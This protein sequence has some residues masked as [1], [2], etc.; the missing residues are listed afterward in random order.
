[1]ALAFPEVGP[2]VNLPFYPLARFDCTPVQS[3]PSSPQTVG[4]DQRALLLRAS[5]SLLRESVGRDSV[6]QHDMLLLL[7]LQLESVSVERRGATGAVQ[8]VRATD[9]AVFFVLTSNWRTVIYDHAAY[10]G[11]RPV[12]GAH[13]W[14][15][16]ASGAQ[17][18]LEAI[19]YDGMQ[20]LLANE[21]AERR[22]GMTAEEVRDAAV[23]GADFNDALALMLPRRSV[24]SVL[25]V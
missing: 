20:Q 17:W 1:V 12:F 6:T 23:F 10:D 22:R 13:A 9:R 18:T 21:R 15:S 25:V 8:F 16:D 24:D 11:G 3:R 4:A 7:R 14:P 19:G 5:Q 2:G